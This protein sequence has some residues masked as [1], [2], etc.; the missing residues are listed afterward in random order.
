MASSSFSHSRVAAS[1]NKWMDDPRALLGP[2]LGLQRR[3][4]QEGPPPHLDFVGP[5]SSERRRN[6]GM[7]SASRA[8]SIKVRQG[9]SGVESR[10]SVAPPSSSPNNL[11]SAPWRAGPT[12]R[13]ASSSAPWRAGRPKPTPTATAPRRP[14]VG[15]A[16]PRAPRPQLPAAFARSR[17]TRP[18]RQPIL[19]SELVPPNDSPV[20][21]SHILT[22][23]AMRPSPGGKV[24]FHFHL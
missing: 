23:K 22:P 20:Q 19:L 24:V 18:S 8:P 7:P 4:P 12:E 2:E 15:P 3:G 10:A 5:Q 14:H 11:G 6:Q 16:K 1:P 9:V 17:S 21:P 13:A